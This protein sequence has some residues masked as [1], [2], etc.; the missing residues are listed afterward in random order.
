MI[1]SKVERQVYVLIKS[2]VKIFDPIPLNNWYVS[3]TDRRTTLEYHLQ[4]STRKT[5]KIKDLVN[6]NEQLTKTTLP[7]LTKLNN[8]HFA[9]KIHASQLSHQQSI[10]FFSEIDIA[11]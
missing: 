6:W 11:F 10:F 1:I 8:Y 7:L 4:I 9:V 5:S 3:H 2:I